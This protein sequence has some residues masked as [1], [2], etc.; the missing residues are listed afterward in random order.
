[1]ALLIVVV[2]NTLCASGTQTMSPVWLKPKQNQTKIFFVCGFSS[3]FFKRY[4]DWD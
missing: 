1:M 3:A 2:Q 4:Q